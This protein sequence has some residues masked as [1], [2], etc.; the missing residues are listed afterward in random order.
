MGKNTET[1]FNIIFKIFIFLLF[2]FARTFTGVSLFGFRLGEYLIGGSMVLLVLYFFLIPLKNKS[3]YLDNKPLNLTILGLVVSFFFTCFI[4]TSQISN[5]FIFKTSSYIWSIGAIILGIEIVKFINIKVG[6]LDIFLS[7]FG[8]LVIY[9][10]STRGI[11]ENLQNFF[12]NFT[13]KFEY[14]KGSDILL[15]FIFIF[16]F[17]LNK[18]E[19]SK[20]SFNLISIF[21]A[22]LAP[23]LMVKSRSAF[24]SAV[25]FILLLIP[26]FRSKINIF[27]KKIIITIFLSAIVFVL[28]TSW[29]VSRDLVVDEEITDE[30]KYAITSRYSTINDNR[31]EE[32]YL[33]LSLF[34]FENGRI[35]STDGNLNWR[36]QIWQDIVNDMW[37]SSL[38]V[39]GYGYEDIIPA[40]NSDQRYGQDKQNINVHNY[41]F[42]IFSRG[43][44]TSVAFALLL[45][46]FLFKLFKQYDLH[47]DYFQITL[48]LLFNSLFDPCMEN[49]H[50]PVIFYLLLGLTFRKYIIF[51]E[52]SD[53]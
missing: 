35:F 32:D 36:F 25:I 29:V 21:F 37:G 6:I 47:L 34:Y 50:Y 2:L 40:M 43:G 18:L 7:L 51:K 23:L 26:S 16:I 30:L 22:L 33:K 20:I 24:F 13:D 14:P 41:F 3:Y 5:L 45:Y 53:N 9:I 38:F 12:L 8:L 19:F 10:F 17:I 46:Y 49:A 27:D 42:H 15:A 1:I 48:P 39:T 4:N 31:Y 28:S 52:E 11:S 44:I